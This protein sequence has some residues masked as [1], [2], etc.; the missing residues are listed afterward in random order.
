MCANRGTGAEISDLLFALHERAIHWAIRSAGD[1]I[2]WNF[3]WHFDLWRD[4]PRPAGRAPNLAAAMGQ[5]TEA[6]KSLFGIDLSA[7]GPQ[8]ASR[9]AH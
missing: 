3:D 6:A 4:K 1:A 2:E 8:A 5:M 7:H 9:P